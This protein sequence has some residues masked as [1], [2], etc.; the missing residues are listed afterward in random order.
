MNVLIFGSTGMIGQGVLRECLEDP[1]I[2]RVTTVGRAPSAVVHAKLRDLVHKDLFDLTPIE[3][4][5]RG[6]EACF[7]CLG[8]SSSG[9][10]EQDY[11]HVTFGMTTGVAETLA[12]LNPNMTFIYVSGKGTDS[13]G[14]GRIMWA[15]VKGRTE[16]TILRLPFKATYMFRVA[17]VLPVHG[18]QSRTSL[19]RFFYAV[20]RPLAPMIQWAFPGQVLTTEDVGRAMI[21]VA[22]SG[23]PK[24]V[25]ESPDIRDCVYPESK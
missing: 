15:R 25:L 8:P 22:R 1:D 9:M 7:Y 2:E 13:S 16:N 4:D 18:E 10:T 21:Q 6:F 5:L 11:E 17:A 14:K 20:T 3:D 23:A 12:R 24:R 19:Y